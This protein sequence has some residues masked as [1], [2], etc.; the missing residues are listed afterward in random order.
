MSGSGKAHVVKTPNQDDNDSDSGQITYIPFNTRNHQ[1]PNS[2]A[3]R[4]TSSTAC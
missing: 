1:A 2:R 4:D 3:R